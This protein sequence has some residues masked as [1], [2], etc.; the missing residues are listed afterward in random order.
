[1]WFRYYESWKHSWITVTWFMFVNERDEDLGEFKR[2]QNKLQHNIV[3]LETKEN[4]FSESVHIA[5]MW[6]NLKLNDFRNSNS[7]CTKYSPS[8]NVQQKQWRHKKQNV[9]FTGAQSYLKFWYRANYEQK[10]SFLTFSYKYKKKKTQWPLVRKRA[11]PIEQSP[12]VGE[13]QCR[14]LR[15]EGCRVVSGSPTVINLCFL[16]RSRYFSFK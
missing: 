11:I 16:D 14:L 6:D 10:K 7:K 5:Q 4:G 13:I 2:L 12:L 3:L 8:F 15:I 1:M 9:Y